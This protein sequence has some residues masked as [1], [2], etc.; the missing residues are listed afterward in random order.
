[1]RSARMRFRKRPR[2]QRKRRPRNA[3]S[4]CC[5]QFQA[6]WRIKPENLRQ[7]A[8]FAH[9]PEINDNASCHPGRS[10]VAVGKDYITGPTTKIARKP[11]TYR[12]RVRNG[13]YRGS[14]QWTGHIAN[15][16]EPVPAP[17][18]GGC[19]GNKNG[20]LWKLSCAAHERG[21]K[22]SGGNRSARL[23]WLTASISE[24]VA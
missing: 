21:A 16:R 2:M 7:F 24:I 23:R 18:C 9:Y 13:K 4:F 11:D 10:G 1:M 15:T 17:T 12:A 6:A 20:K 14:N 22:K 5:G 8:A 3:D 19:N